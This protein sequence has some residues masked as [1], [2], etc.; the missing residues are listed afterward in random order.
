MRL[1]AKDIKEKVAVYAPL[2]R[3]GLFEVVFELDEIGAGQR[4]H[5]LQLPPA[6]IILWSASTT[7]AAA[8]NCK[9]LVRT[10]DGNWQRDLEQPRNH[11]VGMCCPSA[12]SSCSP[13]AGRCGGG[14]RATA[15][16][17]PSP[18]WP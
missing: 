11:P 7:I 12:G 17:G 3:A 9:L 2:P 13:A 10:A 18:R 5:A 8:I 14:C 6:R 1:T 15:C 16:I 4:R